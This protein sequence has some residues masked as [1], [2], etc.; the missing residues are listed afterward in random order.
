[1][2]E[3]VGSNSPN[4]MPNGR[5]AGKDNRRGQVFAEFRKPRPVEEDDFF[6]TYGSSSNISTPEPKA[7]AS[8]PQYRPN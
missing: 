2:N 6:Q 5:K 8:S 3:T 4:A 7:P 1:M